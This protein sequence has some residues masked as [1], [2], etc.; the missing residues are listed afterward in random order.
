[1]EHFHLGQSLKDI[2]ITNKMQYQKS[3]VSK[4][5]SFIGRLRWK[6]FAIKNPGMESKITYGF[7][8]SNPPPQLQQLKPFEEDLFLLVKNIQFRPV[9]NRFQSELSNKIKNIHATNQV[10]VKADKTNNIYK[11][12]VDEYRSLKTQNVTA[13]YKK[14][15]ED[16]IEKINKEAAEIASKLNLSDRIDKFVEVDAFLT[17]KDHKPN[18]PS[19]VECRLLNPAKSNIGKISKQILDEAIISIK[20]QTKANLWTNSNEVISWFKK[21]ENKSTLYFF[22]FDIVSFYPS[23]SQKLFD[24]TI[25][26]AQQYFNFT[27]DNLSIIMNARKSFLFNNS[28]PWIKK[29]NPNFD[30]TMGAFDGAEVCELVGLFI[31]H[32]LEHIIPKHYLGIY[33]DDGLAVVQGS[34]PELERLRKA[35]FTIFKNLQLK[36]T[37]ETNI[38]RTDFLDIFL[39]LQNNTY[40]PFR[41]QNHQPIYINKASNHPPAIKKQLPHMISTRL[42]TLSC[43]EDAF[44][45]E[46]PVYQAALK[47]AGYDEQLQF[48]KCN[49]VQPKKNRARKVIWFNPPF[50]QTVRT[51]VGAKFLGLVDKHFKNTELSRYF[52]RATIKVSY[53]CMSNLETI[54]SGHNKKILNQ[55]NPVPVQTCNCRNGPSNCPLKGNCLKSSIVYRAEVKAADSIATYL[56]AAANSFKE[57]YRNHTLSFNNKKYEFSTS[58]SKHVWNLKSNNKPFTISWTIAGKD[59]PYNPVAKLCKLCLLE[60]TLILISSEPNSINKRSELMSKCRHRAKFLLSNI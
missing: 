4:V 7:K 52:N 34:G 12:P 33:R 31:L 3:I 27:N 29:T 21:L 11:I 1:M 38:K 39:D 41:K 49:S 10:L 25:S 24:D 20:T 50:S 36:V 46:A 55:T 14:A 51:N 57:R 37:L 5:E 26:W 6:L 32:K 47:T 45:S 23:I 53:S 16:E 40:K 19:K 59:P 22:K 60:K 35:V 9:Y 43:S 2:P 28:E 44:L 30:V 8:T 48:K 13:E 17:I 15:S 56:G 58:L 18:F 42:S 54:I